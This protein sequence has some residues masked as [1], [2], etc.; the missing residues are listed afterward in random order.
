MAKIDLYAS[1]YRIAFDDWRGNF[2]T[3]VKFL[4]AL[5]IK[6]PLTRS[7][8]VAADGDALITVVDGTIE[9]IELIREVIAEHKK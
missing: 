7:V 4:R 3:V 2:P 9:T 5:K 1:V 6:I 8:L